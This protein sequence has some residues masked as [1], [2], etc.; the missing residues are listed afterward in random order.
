MRVELKSCL[1]L[2]AFL[3]SEPCFTKE[4]L[5]CMEAVLR[6]PFPVQSTG[7]Y[8]NDKAEKPREEANPATH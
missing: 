4:K 6:T 5:T 7:C 1:S 3:N 8:L 2:R